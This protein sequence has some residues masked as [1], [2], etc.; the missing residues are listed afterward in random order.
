MRFTTEVTEGHRES[1]EGVNGDPTGG[2]K[3][4][5]FVEGS[6][7]GS[8]TEAT[9]VFSTPLRTPVQKGIGFDRM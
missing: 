4:H 5:E 7:I 6:K 1:S 3:W 8:S 9:H 2:V